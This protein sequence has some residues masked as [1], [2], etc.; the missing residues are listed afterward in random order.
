MPVPKPLPVCTGACDAG[1]D[2]L[3]PN[4]PKSP[5]PLVVCGCDV[6]APSDIPPKKPPVV[7]GFVVF[8][9]SP[10]KMFCAGAV[11][12]EGVNKLS[13]GLDVLFR[14]P[15]REV[16]VIDDGAKWWEGC[17]SAARSC[18]MWEWQAGR[19]TA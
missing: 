15:K 12:L 3:L 6:D 4:P 19:G 18:C 13:E 1:A 17:A 2:R 8:E 14:F 5:P 9:L 10:P 11:E 16:I 7:V